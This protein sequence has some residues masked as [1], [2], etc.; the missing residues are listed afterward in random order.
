[1]KAL[2]GEGRERGLGS[3]N[4]GT[5]DGHLHYFSYL[6]LK[7]LVEKQGFEMV[8]YSEGVQTPA[9]YMSFKRC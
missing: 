5:Y 2:D 3:P 8:E 6:S 4:I 9:L 7:T 1:M